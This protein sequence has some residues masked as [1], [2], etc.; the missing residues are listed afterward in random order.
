MNS[1]FM[2]CWHSTGHA[3]ARDPEVVAEVLHPVRGDLG[4]LDHVIHVAKAR[5]RSFCLRQDNGNG[6]L[7]GERG[8]ECEYLIN[9][10][11][12]K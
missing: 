7:M 1:R 2:N 11:M 6:H 9:L 8:Q 10:T 5:V 4:G 12:C 3:R